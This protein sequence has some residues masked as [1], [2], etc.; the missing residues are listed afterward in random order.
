MFKIRNLQVKQI[1][2]TLIDSIEKKTKDALIQVI[3]FIFII[4]RFCDDFMS[5][6]FK[7]I[8]FTTI[9]RKRFKY[10]LRK[11]LTNA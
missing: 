5:V 3:G 4:L 8:L 7:D 9:V 10:K 2:C 6:C 1:T 11:V